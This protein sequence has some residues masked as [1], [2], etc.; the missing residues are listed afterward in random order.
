ME[1]D[2]KVRFSSDDLQ[3]GYTGS[4]QVSEI[5]SWNSGILSEILKAYQ[6]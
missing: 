5:I 4:N 1:K 2:V 6:Q 3:C